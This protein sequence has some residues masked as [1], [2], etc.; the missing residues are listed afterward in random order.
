[1][2]EPSLMPQSPVLLVGQISI[3]PVFGWWAVVPLAI[4]MFAS[5]WLTLSVQGISFRRRLLLLLLRLGAVLILLLGWLRP[6]MITSIERESAGAIAILMDRSESMTLPSDA[7]DRNRWEVQR[8]VWGAIESSTGLKIG[9]TQLI[10]YFYDS[11]ISAAPSDDLPG[12]RKTFD[13]TPRGRA[14]DLGSVLEAVGSV[15]IEPPLRGVILIGDGTQT[16]LPAQFDP[17]VA[18]RQMAQLDQPILMIGIGP[19]SEKSLL[20]DVAVEGLPDQFSAFVKKELSVPLV[21]HAQAMQ[22]QPIRLTATL[23]AGDQPDKIVASRTVMASRAK[24]R[25]PL[26]FKITVDEPGEYL[27]AVE[28]KVDAREQVTTNNVAM[29]FITVRE[30]G[31][32]ILYLEGQPRAEQLFLKRSLDESLDFDADYVWFQQKFRRSWPKELMRNVD[33]NSYD[34]FI[35]GDLDAAALSDAS[36]RAIAR[37]VNRGAGLLLLGGYHSFDGGGWGRSSLAPLFPVK[38]NRPRQKWDAPIDQRLH[39]LHDIRLHPTRPHPITNL[40]PEPDN[41][42]LWKNLKPLKGMNRMGELIPAP[43]TQI[44]LESQD[45]DP[46]MIG[47][48]RGKGRVLAFAGDTTYQW[49]LSGQRKIHQQFWRQAMLWLIRRDRL[50]E[51]FLMSLEQR[52]LSI[53]ATPKLTIEWF[54]GSENKPLPK[55]IKIEMRREQKWLQ[56]LS[57]SETEPNILQSQISGLDQAGL[58]SLV[59]TATSDDD[60]KYTSDLAF[61]VLD[62]SI[63]LATPAADWQ[64]MDNIASANKAAGGQ[65]FLPEEVGQAI[66]WLRDR[67]DAT[68][69][70]TIEKRRLGDAAWDAWLYLAIFSI[71]LSI[72]WALRKSWQ[73]P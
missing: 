17:I 51:G 54:G 32:K 42:Q 52:R 12:L 55:Q 1:M 41:T 6:A 35:F 63:E 44:L 28:A 2:F 23:R 45:G 19:R 30:G 10:P 39:I 64:M 67:Q 37:R 48:E 33:L 53:D 36:L 29:S 14:T 66:K 56:N 69:M 71:L 72:E 16:R 25:L 61:V 47:A 4:I 57:S 34:V 43:G 20:R 46:V 31:V 62:E 9:Q 15:Q 21:V 24:E 26:E 22:N 38:M 59:L 49:W 13:K 7:T 65:L 68:K 11:D 8:D 50:Q 27:L 73:L 3:E 5:L 40:L 58:Y 70:T 18:A 60:K